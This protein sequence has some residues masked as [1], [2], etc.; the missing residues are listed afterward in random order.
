MAK[1]FEGN[2]FIR[3]IYH[4]SEVQQI[5]SKAIE[6]AFSEELNSLLISVEGFLGELRDSGQYYYYGVPLRDEAGNI[7]LLDIPKRKVDE[8]YQYRKV[9]ATGTLKI[10]FWRGRQEVRLDVVNLRA[11]SETDPE[12]VKKEVSV[13]EL[14]RSYRDYNRSFPVKT[15]YNIALIYPSTSDVRNDF[16]RQLVEIKHLKITYYPVNIYSSEELKQ[17]IE[18]ADEDLIVLVRG[19]GDIGEFEVFNDKDLVSVWS[20]KDAYRITALGHTGHRFLIDMFSNMSCDTP[21]AAG[22]FIKENI[23][24][25]RELEEAKTILEKIDKYKEKVIIYKVTTVLL[26]IL[27]LLSL[28]TK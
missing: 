11:E 1:E 4:I 20:K 21:T 15:I 27:F 14:V 12:L 25:V 28:L 26:A 16:L 2:T 19:G 23:K 7:L 17:A 9:T 3:H 22:V 24:R 10:H 18:A 8:T 5:I 13:M 6:R